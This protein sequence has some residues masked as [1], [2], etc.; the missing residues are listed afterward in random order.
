MFMFPAEIDFVDK[1]DCVRFVFNTSLE[2]GYPTFHNK[3]LLEEIM[4]KVIWHYQISVNLI[5]LIN[6]MIARLID[7]WA[8]SFTD[9]YT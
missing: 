6:Q 2:G 4:T 1:Q 8:I 3:R 9:F 7:N 5:T